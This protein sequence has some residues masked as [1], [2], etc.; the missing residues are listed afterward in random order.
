MDHLVHQWRKSPSPVNRLPKPKNA[1]EQRLRGGS[2]A[3]DVN[4][5]PQQTS[6]DSNCLHFRHHFRFTW[7]YSVITCNWTVSANV[8]WQRNGFIIRVFLV[9]YLEQSNCVTYYHYCMNSP[10]GIFFYKLINHIFIWTIGRILS[11]PP[12]FKNISK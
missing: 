9:Y 8:Q 3:G 4:V 6:S 1:V 11:K 5:A 10:Y 7:K 2:T 12:S